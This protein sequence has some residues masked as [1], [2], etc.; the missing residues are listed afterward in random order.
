MVRMTSVVKAVLRRTGILPR[1]RRACRNECALALE[2]VRR[3]VTEAVERFDRL[4]K[5][6]SARERLG[7]RVHELERRLALMA[8][9]ARIDERQSQLVAELSARVDRKGVRAH[10]AR[11][12]AGS[13]LWTEP[14]GHLLVDE[15]FPPDFYDL[16]LASLPPPE[17]FP[18]R[19]S[20]GMNL[21]PSDLDGTPRLTRMVWSF[22]E[23]DLTRAMAGAAL[24]RLGPWVRSRYRELFA[25]DELADAAAALR[26]EPS[27]AQLVL[28]RPGYR[29]RPHLAP[30][31]AS[32]TVLIYLA[33][34]GDPATMGTDLYAL[35]GPVR[36]ARTDTY[37]P[38]DH[39]TTCTLTS[40]IPFRANSAL[41]VVNA[42]AAQGE[43]FPADGGSGD[44]LRYTY[45]FHLEPSLPRLLRLVSKL[46]PANQQLWLGLALAHPG[47]A[48][49]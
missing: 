9:V 27:G 15:V 38:E 11:T 47:R 5:A 2:E 30:K 33:R 3:D 28:R 42:G 10:V 44:G 32:V 43:S 37:Y 39:G 46:P 17:F 23:S 29:L 18:S 21:R 13:V 49:E 24:D 25:D 34:A 1:L 40:R 36:P 31:K 26:H 19:H 20:F 22:V 6:V 4:Q 7:A 12:V 14:C 16:L 45:Q 48:G 8:L 35:S 41:I